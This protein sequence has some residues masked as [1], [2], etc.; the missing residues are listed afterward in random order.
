MSLELHRD[1][2]TVHAERAVLVSVALPNR[3]WVGTDPLDELHGL[4]TTAGATVV[5][6]LLQ[7]RSKST[8]PPTS[9]RARSRNWT[10]PSRRPMPTSSSST[11]T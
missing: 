11:T 5:G 9:A 2:L 10:R 1:K 6:G 4:A 8:T 3:P 7:K